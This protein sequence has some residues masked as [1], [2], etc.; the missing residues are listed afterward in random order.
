MLC[1]PLRMTL[2]TKWNRDCCCFINSVWLTSQVDDFDD[3]RCFLVNVTRTRPHPVLIRR[4]SLD[5]E[6][7][8][9]VLVRLTRNHQNISITNKNKLTF[10]P[11][12]LPDEHWQ[13]KK[14]IYFW[15]FTS[16]ARFM[17]LEQ[18]CWCFD[19]VNDLPNVMMNFSLSKI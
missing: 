19:V 16:Y 6:N 10:L 5:L 4:G 18:K 3:Y 12:M 11:F 7:D 8:R 15:L 14:Y 1:Q 2:E 9:S 13:N 17:P